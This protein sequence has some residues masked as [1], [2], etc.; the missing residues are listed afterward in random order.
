VNRTNVPNTESRLTIRDSQTTSFRRRER[1]RHFR[2][3]LVATVVAFWLILSAFVR[4]NSLKVL[5]SKVANRIWEQEVDGSS[6]RPDL[7]SMT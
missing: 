2:L 3:P 1:A 4:D 6:I 5:K 7:F